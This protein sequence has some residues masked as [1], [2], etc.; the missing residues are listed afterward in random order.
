MTS[1]FLALFALLPAA[2]ATVLLTPD[3]AGAS[4]QADVTNEH[5]VGG[6]FHGWHRFFC[7]PGAT[8]SYTAETEHDHGN[9]YVSINNSNNGNLNCDDLESGSAFAICS[10]SGFTTTN[11]DSFHEAPLNCGSL[12]SDGHGIDCHIMEAEP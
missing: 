4:C 9:K 5:T 6:V 3:T 8:W 12:Y 10:K 1:T 2:G 7:Q 11:H